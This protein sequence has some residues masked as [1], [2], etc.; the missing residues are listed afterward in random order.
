MTL[1]AA[2]ELTG[3]VAGDAILHARRFSVHLVALETF[4][5]LQMTSVRI[6]FEMMGCPSKIRILAM[7]SQAFILG[8]FQFAE[9]YV[10]AFSNRH[11]ELVHE[12]GHR[13]RMAALTRDVGKKVT[14]GEEIRCLPRTDI[15][16][17][18]VA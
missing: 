10:I 11:H 2:H 14:V 9:G 4:L 17:H 8:D 6:V 13:L 15:R 7:T 1:A 12:I 18:S 16:F 3:V 5:L